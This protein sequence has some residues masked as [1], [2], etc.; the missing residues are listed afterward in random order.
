L[1]SSDSLSP[2]IRL[3]LLVVLGPLCAT[4]ARADPRPATIQGLIG[5]SLDPVGIRSDAA[6]RTFAAR[7]AQTATQTLLN[8]STSLGQ[9]AGIDATM[10]TMGPIVLAHPQTLGQG[11]LNVSLLGQTALL[12]PELAGPGP[13]V[14]ARGQEEFA[15]EIG[16][17]LR[18]RVADAAL[19]ATYGLTDELDVSLVVLAVH[20]ALAIDVTRQIVRQNVDGTF[21]PTRR[22][23]TRS[24]ETIS[25]TGFGDLTLRVKYRLPSLGPVQL[26]ASTEVQF[27]TGKEA[28]LLGT[29]DYWITPTLSA[30]ILLG[31]RADTTLNVGLDFDVNRSIR[32]QALYGLGTSYLLIPRRLIGVVEVLGRSDLDARPNVNATAAFYL[33][34]DGHVRPSPLF[35]LSFDRRDYVDL[36]FGV[37]IV[38]APGLIAFASGIYEINHVGLHGGRIIPTIGL[39][40][41][42]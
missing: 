18:L 26:A 11:R 14:I 24:R 1:R 39:G 36:S 28:N 9:L 6:L 37:R 21:V 35:G 15:A 23:I 4:L 22:P 3:A 5:R 27:P 16:Y 25:N 17:Q 33:F 34:P 13:L 38:L 29:G 19:V 40:T 10:T 31:E 30:H 8:G 7:Y 2:P 12:D 20:A 42:W 32:S 41:V